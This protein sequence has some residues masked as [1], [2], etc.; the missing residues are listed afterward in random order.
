MID[1]KAGRNKPLLCLGSSPVDIRVET[2]VNN[3]SRR[4]A[5]CPGRI[6]DHPG[7]TIQIQNISLDKIEGE[8]VRS[9]KNNQEINPLP[10]SN[11]FNSVAKLI[12][13]EEE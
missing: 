7:Q 4:L 9:N 12:R 10:V 11:D 1:R 5:R 3:N 8:L 6:Y 2:R 13:A